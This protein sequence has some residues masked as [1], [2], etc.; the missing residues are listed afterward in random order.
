MRSYAFVGTL[1]SF[2]G[3]REIK[4]SNKTKEEIAEGG[5]FRVLLTNPS[6]AWEPVLEEETYVAYSGAQSGL[7][8]VSWLVLFVMLLY[9]PSQQLWSLRDG[10]FT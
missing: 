5:P 10:Q 1:A 7:V 6:R 9:V 4:T 3:V 8:S 2:G